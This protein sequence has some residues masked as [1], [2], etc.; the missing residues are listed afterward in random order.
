MTM[1]IAVAGAHL[2]GFS[3]IP[4]HLIAALQQHADVVRWDLPRYQPPLMRRVAARLDRKQYLWDK[5]P[6]RC[7]FH[8]RALDELAERQRVDAVLLIGS[9]SGAFSRTATPIFGF[10]DSIFGS[11]VD[12]YADQMLE[13]ISARS[14][15]EGIDVQQRALDKMRLFFSTSQWAWD[16]AVARFRYRVDPR[17]L[18]VT[19]VGAN[20]PHTPAA[21]PVAT[22]PP[23]FL[24][25][26]TD[27]VRKRGDFA[28]A[29]VRA[30]RERG[31][32]AELDLVGPVQLPS[33]PAWVRVHG[34]LT[35]EN[36][37]AERYAAATALLLPTAADLTPVV[38][39]EAA[40][41]GR[42]AIASPAGAIPEMIRDG[43]S[44]LVIAGDDP[45]AW[46]AIIAA[47]VSSLP[48]LGNVARRCY[49]EQLNWTGIAAGMVR[50]MEE[51]L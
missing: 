38:I 11:R 39:A 1:R 51:M 19:L 18:H 47:N 4:R 27:W 24:W 29:V 5:D 22:T 28:I 45:S 16:R 15:R 37:L 35:A 30:L 2:D 31:L 23:R 42:P 32:D 34:P 50:R 26:G 25:V 40:M 36:G 43:E 46:A 49:E 13:R 44:G 7:A 41:M 12:L 14:V 17:R 20:L 48:R 8:S 9:E 33:S 10:G 6:R 3:G 21:L